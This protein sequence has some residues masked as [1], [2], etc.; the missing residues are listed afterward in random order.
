MEIP[1][2]LR[3]SARYLIVRRGLVTVAVVAGIAVTLGLRAAVR[4]RA[5]AGRDGPHPWRAG[6]GLALRGP[7]GAG[8]PPDLA[9]GD[10]APRSC[11]LPWRLRCPAPADDAGGANP[12]GQRPDD[13][14]GDDRSRGAAGAAPEDAAGV[15]ARRRRLDVRG[16]GAR[17]PVRRRRAACR[18]APRSWWTW[19]GEGGRCWS[20]PRSS[21]RAAPGRRW[22][23]CCRRRWCRWLADRARSRVACARA[24]AVGRAVFGRGRVPAGVGGH[25]V[26]PGAREHPAGRTHGRAHGGRSAR[27]ART[28]NRARR[29]GETAAAGSARAGLARLR[30]RLPPGAH[31]RRR[32]LRLR[33]AGARPFRPGAGRHLGQGHLGGA[34]DGQ[35]AGQ[36]ARAVR[37]RAA[38][39]GAGAVRPSTR[40]SSTPRRRTTT[41]RC[42]SASITR[43]TARCTTPTAGTCRRSCC[44]PTARW[45]DWA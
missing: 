16:G 36:P 14:R 28:R 10:G 45:S 9:A 27:L 2:L 7:D 37:Q 31:R 22:R 5:V 41:R 18:L 44:G 42:S 26:G 24:A 12:H 40:S 21:S 6:A 30:R 15:P 32:L 20:I 19:R 38:R 35:P 23:R 13:A 33:V 25:A 29:A 1:V 17:R 3:R 8:R 43:P 34:A 11:V 4:Q 39:S